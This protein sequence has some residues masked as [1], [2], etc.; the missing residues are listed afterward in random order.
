MKKVE[1]NSEHTIKCEKINHS[2]TE[3][4]EILWPTLNSLCLSCLLVGCSTLFPLCFLSFDGWFS[5]SFCFS[6]C[7]SSFILLSS[8]HSDWFSLRVYDHVI[9]STK[10]NHFT[11]FFSLWAYDFNWFVPFLVHWLICVHVY[12]I[13]INFHLGKQTTLI[14]V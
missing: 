4:R 11:W 13:Y 8:F 1:A 3:E 12:S 14:S 10:Y 2:G 9:I 6:Y 5:Q 7:I